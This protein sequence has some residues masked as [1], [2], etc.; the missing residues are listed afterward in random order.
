MAGRTS[1]TREP[2]PLT[3][4]LRIGRLLPVLT[5]ADWLPRTIFPADMDTELYTESHT[6]SYMESTDMEHTG[7]EP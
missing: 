7:A 1:E 4:R 2:L 3:A 6:E 5:P